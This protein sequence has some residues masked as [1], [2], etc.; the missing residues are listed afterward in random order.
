[1][2][3][4]SMLSSFS[5]IQFWMSEIIFIIVFSYIFLFA[6]CPGII[7]VG[8]DGIVNEVSYVSLS[9]ASQVTSVSG[10]MTPYLVQRVSLLASINQ[11]L[12]Y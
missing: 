1:M 3:F 4:L 2:V 8:G 12:G 6:K 7:C 5:V 10:C 11:F 9:R